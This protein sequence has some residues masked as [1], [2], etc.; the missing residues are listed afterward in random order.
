MATYTLNNANPEEVFTLGADGEI[1]VLISD[2]TRFNGNA[3]FQLEYETAVADTYIPVPD[4]RTSDPYSRIYKF[5]AGKIK[6]RLNSTSA[7]DDTTV[8]VDVKA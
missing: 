2:D 8:V 5:K 6:A 1:Q 4:T 3:Y 7:T